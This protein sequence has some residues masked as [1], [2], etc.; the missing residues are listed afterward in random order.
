LLDFQLSSDEALELSLS[1]GI[2]GCPPLD[3]LV[4][5]RGDVFEVHWAED[6]TNRLKQIRLESGVAG[7]PLVG[8]KSQV[9][10]DVPQREFPG[11][12][13]N[14]VG[15]GPRRPRRCRVAQL[16]QAPELPDGVDA[17]LTN[18]FGDSGTR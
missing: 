16:D 15:G 10:L 18:R 11:L 13:R 8:L 5:S 17:C 12:R 3:K 7:V 2:I 14:A 9:P 4:S 1:G 6:A